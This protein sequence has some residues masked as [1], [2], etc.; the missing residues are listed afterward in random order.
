MAICKLLN[1]L[2]ISSVAIFLSSFGSPANALSVE[3]HGH[4][5]A[6]HSFHSHDSIARKK[7]ANSK[8]CKTRGSSVSVTSSSSTKKAS[9]TKTSAAS[10]STT[11]KSSNSGKGGSSSS[12]GS[13]N[14]GSSNADGNGSKKAGLAW[15]NGGDSALQYYKGSKT[16]LLY[17]W[18]PHCPSNAKSLG[19][20]CVPMCWGW[21]QVDDFQKTA[22]EGYAKYAMGP[23]E[24]NQDGQSDM[25]PDSGAELW[26]TYLKPLRSKGYTLVSPAV[27]S[28]PNG[29][30]WMKDFFDKIGGTDGVDIVALH[31]YDVGANKFIDYVSDFYTT[32]KKPI[33]V[34]EFACQNFNGGAQC[35]M[36]E[37]WTFM[38]S[39]TKWMDD[40]W[41]IYA[42]FAFGV[43]HDMQ[44]VN[45]DNQ[46]M[47]GSGKPTDLGYMYI[48]A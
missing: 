38:G 11:T 22:V 15:P 9:T 39:V 23:N 33:W 8:R 21:K 44:G 46:L 19:F 2:A 29:K 5:L 32:F 6:R 20:E 16:K 27:T 47:S 48:G 43:M 24:P 7:R 12:S 13:S 4:S 36:D 31:W 26:N 28:A 1:L 34:T 14:S 42:Y 3:S 18:S 45:D 17:T 25:S 10:S 35:T 37:V 40:T 41:Y 30:T